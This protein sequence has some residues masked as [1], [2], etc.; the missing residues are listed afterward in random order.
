MIPTQ[1]AK[2]ELAS[3]LV[4]PR[5][6]MCAAGH[7]CYHYSEASFIDHGRSTPWLVVHLANHSIRDA[8]PSRPQP[9]QVLA[10]RAPRPTGAPPESGPCR[11]HRPPSPA[12]QPEDS[13]G[14][15]RAPVWRPPCTRWQGLARGP[16]ELGEDPR[17]ALWLPF[18]K[19]PALGGLWANL[20]VC[21]GLTLTVITDIRC[22]FKIYSGK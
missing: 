15:R 13:G 14:H 6:R 19:P 2:V 18:C 4:R 17:A 1:F 10:R 16:C 3:S 21:H 20:R 7:G 12:V 22:H 9:G 5:T 11:T 8:E